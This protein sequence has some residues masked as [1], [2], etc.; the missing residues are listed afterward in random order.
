MFLIDELYNGTNT[1]ER[2]AAARAVLE[3]LGAS[4]Q[5]LA[6][7][8][9]VELQD[10]LADSYDLYYFQE[11]PDV[12]GYF[13]YQP[14]PGQTEKRNAIQLLARKGFPS[15]LVAQA[16]AYFKHHAARLGR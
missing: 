12:D 6:T 3:F 10:D 11:D 4:T 8:H 2:L 1:V 9:A 15:D 13:D 7:T 16:M 5:V 14:L